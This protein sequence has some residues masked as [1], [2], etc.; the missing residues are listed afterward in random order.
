MCRSYRSCHAYNWIQSK[1]FNLNIRTPFYFNT[2]R[3]QEEAKWYM[4]KFS[5]GQS[6]LDL[7]QELLDLYANCKSSK[8]ILEVQNSYLEKAQE[9]KANANTDDM[10][11]SSSSSEY[12][13]EEEDQGPSNK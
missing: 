1:I 5:W 7:N 11:P 12:D 2:T 13:E 10:W 9:E 8:E 3:L 6:F 4:S